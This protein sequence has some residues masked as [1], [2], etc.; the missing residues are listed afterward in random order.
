MERL[1]EATP[2]APG[3]PAPQPLAGVA[4]RA[5]RGPGRSV[6]G[7]AIRLANP[8]SEPVGVDHVAVRTGKGVG[9]LGARPD[10]PRA[11]PPDPHP[12]R[13][14]QRQHPGRL[15]ASARATSSAS[16]SEV[17]RSISATGTGSTKPAVGGTGPVSVQSRDSPGCR[18]QSPRPSQVGLDRLLGHRAALFSALA[19]VA[20]VSAR[21][22]GSRHRVQHTWRHETPVLQRSG[23]SRARRRHH[24]LRRH[25]AP[26]A[27]SLHRRR[28]PRPRHGHHLVITF[29][30][31]AR[32]H[33]HSHDGGQVLHVMEGQGLVQSRGEAV[34]RLRPGDVVS[35]APGEE[36][37]HGAAEGA[38]M[39][40]LAVSIGTTRWLK[41]RR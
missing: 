27:G 13:G 12:D 28:P 26:A 6:D 8:T 3:R 19:V 16:R 41:G 18:A 37:W 15:A 34:R 30:N 10:R 1:P 2:T 20:G 21:G 4:R 9:P 14:R 23:G 32:T 11:R 36:H 17:T 35:S 29:E 25:C 31:G 33:W 38:T 24:S 5:V 39:R 7:D 22:G 40:H